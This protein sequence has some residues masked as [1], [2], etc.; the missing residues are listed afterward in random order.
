MI[1]LSAPREEEGLFECNSKKKNHEGAYPWVELHKN[2]KQCLEKL[3][4]NKE[5]L[6]N[7]QIME[8]LMKE[9]IEFTTLFFRYGNQICIRQNEKARV[10]MEQS[11][12]IRTSLAIQ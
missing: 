1:I 9:V 12:N 3:Q 11:F 8:E 7:I 6:L 4:G 5:T 10:T 2:P